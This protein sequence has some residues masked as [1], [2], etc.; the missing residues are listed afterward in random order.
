MRNHKTNR[1]KANLFLDIALA[2]AFLVSLKPFLTGM[3]IHEW[4]GLAIGVALAVHILRHWPWIVAVTAK[5]NRKTPQQVRHYYGLDAALLAGFLS[6]IGSGI[7]MS[8]TA[9]PLFDFRGTPYLLLATF[10]KYVSYG[11]LTLLIVK[12]GLHG[13]WLVNAVKCHVLGMARTPVSAPTA[14]VPAPQ[15]AAQATLNRRQFLVLGCGAVCAAA[16]LGKCN[17]QWEADDETAEAAAIAQD[18]DTVAIV[19]NT[20]IVAQSTVAPTATSTPAAVAAESTEAAVEVVAQPTPTVAA[21]TS[22]STSRPTTRCPHG[23]VN[24]P[25]PGRCRRY[26]DKNG[27]GICDYSETA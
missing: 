14:P 25:Y 20:A 13:K 19:Q 11:T 18:T 9:L 5:L 4:L 15:R 12:L 27:N 22:P 24:D 23:L 8:Q 26:T 10:H 21:A 6:I 2:G 3:A 16:L 1:T 7:L 17:P